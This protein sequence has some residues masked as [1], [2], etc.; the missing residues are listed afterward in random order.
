MLYLIVTKCVLVWTKFFFQQLTLFLSAY[1][2]I[3]SVLFICQIYLVNHRISC[4][5]RGSQGYWFQF[6]A[7]H[8]KSEISEQRGYWRGAASCPLY[9]GITEHQITED[10][11]FCKSTL[12]NSLAEIIFS[13]HGAEMSLKKMRVQPHTSKALY[14]PKEWKGLFHMP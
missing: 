3:S 7:L 2:L 12:K 14:W 9:L 5:G 6:L 4:V 8:M 1:G 11:T 10:L 13:C